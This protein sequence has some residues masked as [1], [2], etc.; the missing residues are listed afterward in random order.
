MIKNEKNHGILFI[1]KVRFLVLGKS[2]S[3]LFSNSSFDYGF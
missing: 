3:I 1:L 2:Q